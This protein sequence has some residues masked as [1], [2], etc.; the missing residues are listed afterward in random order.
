[1]PRGD[2]LGARNMGLPARARATPTAAA[3]VL[4]RGRR[5][6][7]EASRRVSRPGSRLSTKDG[8]SYDSASG[9]W[10]EPSVE[11]TTDHSLLAAQDM[12]GDL[13][14]STQNATKLK[15]KML[16]MPQTGHAI[17]GATI[18]WANRHIDIG[19]PLGYS[20]LFEVYNFHVK[21]RWCTSSCLCLHHASASNDA[22]LV[23]AAV[24]G[25]IPFTRRHG[26][27]AHGHFTR[28][29]TCYALLFA[30]GNAQQFA[31][32]AA[33]NGPFLTKYIRRAR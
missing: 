16:K 9:T 10:Q 24:E 29:C 26:L 22:T 25:H 15:A 12:L 32:A 19:T 7:P 14:L 27:G 5:L 28:P 20:P 1:M 11:R 21:D 6:H 3:G 17:N 13:N 23:R 18:D 30:A 4:D 31:L 8:V 33:A 2:F